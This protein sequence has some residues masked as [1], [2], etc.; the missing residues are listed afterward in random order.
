Q[1]VEATGLDARGISHVRFEAED[2]VLS[3]QE[4]LAIAGLF[5][6]ADK[7]IKAKPNEVHLH[8]G[9]FIK[10][11]RDLAQRAGGEAPLPAIPNPP[12]LQEI[13]SLSG[14][15]QL[16]RIHEVHNELND[17]M[18]EW[19]TLENRKRARLALWERTLHALRHADGLTEAEEA[20][21]EVD[22]VREQRTLL[23]EENPLDGLDERIIAALRTALTEAHRAYKEAYEKQMSTL[24]ADGAWQNLD[25]ASRS[26]ILAKSGLDAVP[27]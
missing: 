8:V 14:N 19:G 2:I 3:F 20:R 24:Q 10:T 13:S 26:A 12:L 6:N 27:E 16:R 11:M 9:T 5:N 22:A 7:E 23:A 1:P 21:K 4:K 25:E 15:Q 18:S 17:L